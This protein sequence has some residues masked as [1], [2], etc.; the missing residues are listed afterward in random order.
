MAIGHPIDVQSQNSTIHRARSKQ[1][2]PAITSEFS[3]NRAASRQFSQPSTATNPHL[4]I[5]VI[6]SSKQQSFHQI[7]Y[8]K[9]ILAVQSMATQIQS[10][11]KSTAAES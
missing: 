2:G 7:R 6:T 8:I 9:H 10:N 1:G 3:K 4:Q 5:N 11:A